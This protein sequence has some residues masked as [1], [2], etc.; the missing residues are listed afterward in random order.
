MLRTNGLN[1][2][3]LSTSSLHFVTEIINPALKVVHTLIHYTVKN[4][5]VFTP[6]LYQIISPDVRTGDKEA[7]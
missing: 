1:S 4:V 7:G 5:G 3:V 2:K 6:F